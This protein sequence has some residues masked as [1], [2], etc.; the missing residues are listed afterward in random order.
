MRVV[1]A[2]EFSGVV[3]RAFHNKG[4]DVVSCDLEPSDDNSPYHYQGDIFELLSGFGK[5]DL[6]IAHPPCTY[7]T[8]TGNKWF[9]HPDD[10][11][12]PTSERR[13]HPRFPDRVAQREAGFEFF[14]KLANLDI[15]KIAIENPVGIVSTRWRKPDQIIQPYQFG[16]PQQKKTCLWLKGLPLIVP[17]NIVEP[18]PYHISKNGKK[19]ATWYFMPK[20][21]GEARRKIRNTTFKG[22]GEAFA[23]QWGNK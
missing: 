21:R 8:V 20:A 19:C 14:M 22:I 18:E 17:T 6:M 2:C 16:H 5:V 12:L 9:Y 1:I 11:H 4:H 15:P 13:P 3:R 10:K 23:D 7:L